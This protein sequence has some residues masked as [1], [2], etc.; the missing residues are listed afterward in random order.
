[1]KKYL[2]LFLCVIGVLL[3]GNFIFY[4]TNFHISFGKDEPDDFFVK[5]E[6]KEIFLNSG[7]GF[8]K[9]EIK[10][11]D[12]GAGIPGH[13]ATDYAIDEET[14]L[15]WFQQ[16][17]EMG[18]N[19]IRVYTILGPEFYQAFYDYNQ[20]REEP[21]YLIHGLWVQDYVINNHVD[22]YDDTFLGQMQKDGKT[23]VDILHGKKTVNLGYGTSSAS[24]SYR[25]DIS[26]WVIGYILGVEWEAPTIAYTNRMQEDRAPF[27]GEYFYTT[28]DATPFEA[29]L[30]RVGET[31]VG[32]ESRK[33]HQQ[34]LFAFSNWPAS[35]PFMYP[36][37][38]VKKFHKYE[39]IDTENIKCTDL[40]RSGQFASY[41]IYPYY[42]D[43]LDYY[44]EWKNELE[45]PDSFYEDGK[46]NTYRAYLTLINQHHTMPVVISEFGLPAARGMA[47][48]DE[49]T[50][51]NQGH[52]NEQEQAEG[53]RE[54][55]EDIQAAGCA[56]QV[57]FSWQDEWFKRSWNTYPNVNFNRTAYWSDFQT[58]EQSFGLLTF[59]PGEEESVCY[60]DGDAGEW[61]DEDLVLEREEYSLFMKYDEKFVY[62]MID[63]KDGTSLESDQMFL[64]L[65]TTPKTGSLYMK[66]TKMKLS[67]MADFALVMN[68][69]QDTRLLVQDRYNVFR[70][71]WSQEAYN[72]NAYDEYP[73]KN[74]PVFEPIYLLLKMGSAALGGETVLSDYYETG[75]LTYGNGNPEA[76]DFNSIADFMCSGRTAEIRLPWQLLNFSDPSE[77]KIYDDYYENYGV[78]E[79][80]IDSLYAGIG[81][82]RDAREGI[83]IPFGNLELE[84]W[85][86]NP[87]YHERLKL[88]Y[89][90]VKKMW[91][92]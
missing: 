22:A 79:I 26:Q 74:S 53:I 80:S 43:Y 62:F 55:Y 92:Q 59:D 10:G 40:F 17:Q 8:N 41:H 16:I 91:A 28:E 1:M 61:R 11:V 70:A 48:R 33:Y 72:E 52:I 32:Y 44:E 23:M 73:D 64:F 56:G 39:K 77:M 67:R 20:D 63:K 71:M 49:N 51:R 65:D 75:V 58:N 82:K 54:C 19:T 14:Y 69:P 89:Y 42:P 34:R 85:G 9:F 13:F 57:I 18:A 15:R 45:D 30:A 78:E 36:N 31:V 87:T 84:G 27:T 5:T 50:G 25:R 6:G 46:L 3:A 29:M 2:I 47:Q 86:E 76:E 24:G 38:V 66:D 60:V 81:T 4:Q 88:A 90:T 7:D 21:L 35:D 68:G 12:M 83:R 37:A